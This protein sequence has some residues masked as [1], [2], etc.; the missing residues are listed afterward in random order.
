MA[1]GVTVLLMVNLLIYN[2]GLRIPSIIGFLMILSS[3][4][5]VVLRPIYSR[6]L[7]I[8]TEAYSIAELFLAHM[9]MGYALLLSLL[10]I[11]ALVEFLL[12][13]EFVNIPIFLV[14]LIV[15]AFSIALTYYL[16]TLLGH[17][18]TTYMVILG[19][20][21]DYFVLMLSSS[22]SILILFLMTIILKRIIPRLHRHREK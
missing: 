5:V 12:L 8:I 2:L 13:N 7:F 6:Y 18:V 20:N 17:V 9:G 15:L 14:S 10:I 16:Y 19:V 1:V 11:S 3:Y 4:I 21:I 22:L